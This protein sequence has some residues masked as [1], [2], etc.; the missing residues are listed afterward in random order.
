MIGTKVGKSIG[1]HNDSG[2]KA[3]GEYG[4]PPLRFAQVPDNRLH[5]RFQKRMPA[6][7]IVQG[8]KLVEQHRTTVDPAEQRTGS[9]FRGTLWLV[10]QGKFRLAVWTDVEHGFL[11]DS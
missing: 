9:G 7:L 8:P 11:V 5:L 1:Y 4:L 6:G 10:K 3:D 2:K